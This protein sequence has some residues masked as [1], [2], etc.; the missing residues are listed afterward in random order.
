MQMVIH[1][2]VE[3]CTEERDTFFGDRSG[4]TIHREYPCT[5]WR[6]VQWDGDTLSGI[7]RVRTCTLVGNRFSVGD[8]FQTQYFESPI[9]FKPID[10]ILMHFVQINFRPNT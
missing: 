8:R 6:D 3:R 5:S 2:Q 4:W 9:V 10:I 1:V 7:S